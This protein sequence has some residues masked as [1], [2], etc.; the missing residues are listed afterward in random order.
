VERKHQR[1]SLIASSILF[2]VLVLL[3]FWQTSLDFGELGPTGPTE[4][5]VLWA[6]S[7]LVVL[8]VFTLGFIVFRSLLKLYIERRQNRL[9]S[10][11]KTKLVAG[12]FI[13]S[14]V[15][16]IC[17][18][19]FSFAM[20]NRTLDKWFTRLPSQLLD[21]SYQI[22][23][24]LREIVPQKI[25]TD[26]RWI[27]SLPA[28]QRGLRRGEVEDALRAQLRSFVLAG[29]SHYVALLPATG[30]SP[31]VEFSS[32][33]PLQGPAEWRLPGEVL[34]EPSGVTVVSAIRSDFAYAFAPVVTGGRT[35]G[36]VVV[37]WRVPPNLAAS[38]A[39]I[40][41]QWNDYQTKHQD[42][43]SYRYF[44]SG[45]LA[46][47]SVFVLFVATWLA[48]FLSKQI[49]VPIEAL[50]EATGKLS[51]GHLEHRVQAPASDELASLV[52]SFNQMTQQLEA[53]TGQLQQR[54]EDLGRANLELDTRRR[55]INA[56]LESI[57]AGVISVSAK[58]AIL[59]TNSALSQIFP[60][61][62]VRQAENIRDLFSPEDYEELRYMM[63]RAQRLGSA[64]REFE[65]QLAGQIL[66]LTVTVSAIGPVA[67]DGGPE[68]PRFVIV[69]EDTTELLHAQ[70]SAAW[71]EVARRVAHEIKNPLTPIALSAERMARL[72]DRLEGARDPKER[73][74][75]RDRFVQCTRTIA[76]EVETLR[77]LVDEFAQFAR[78]PQARPVRAD[79]NAVVESAL[80][81]FQGRLDG[82]TVRA[83]LV[84]P[85]PAVHLD[86]ALFKRVVVNLID[87]AA[88]ALQDCW[89]K[90]IVISTAAGLLP[91]T[92]ELI[93][94]DSGPGISPEDKER[95]FLPYFSTKRRGTGLGLAIVNRVLGEHHATIR[96]ED[97]QPSG[98]RFIIDVPT[99]DSVA[100]VGTGVRV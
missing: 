57:T 67:V 85:L 1:L 37:A 27:A 70:K 39:E 32:R 82:I 71:D 66:H 11:I 94:A 20:L 74:D 21:H 89:V 69:L 9:G 19:I 22:S 6:I 52:E 31:L 42:L 84:R 33:S 28:V 48:L 43:R 97:N 5:V 59:K 46:L 14:I 41:R 26:A 78:F 2:L 15:P 76:G 50:V 99:A 81:S 73:Q 77:T 25:E 4:T 10:Q 68:P 95:L 49:I 83:E 88:E 13:L 72:L 55:F 96:V 34:R 44:Y 65:M 36:R 98:S 58:D 79:L 62:K 45:V 18:V 60:A 12:A 93:V 91:D 75:L 3:A 61:D 56:M 100:V 63:K 90:E 40:E 30:N 87:N 7:T 29:N 51:S 16:V 47:I 64:S 86:P 92:V 38:R 8:G 35:V 54:N 80:E 53:Q 17:L 24:G 23:E